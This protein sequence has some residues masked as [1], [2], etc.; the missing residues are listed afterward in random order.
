M[1][2][3]KIRIMDKTFWVLLIPAMLT[4]I[5]AVAAV[6]G[7]ALDLGDVGNRLLAVVEALFL[8]L[9]IIGIVRDPTTPG[10]DDSQRAMR[11]VEPGVLPEA[12]K[13]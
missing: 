4:L 6:F 13:E 10:V 7:F 11:Y 8:V 1:I 5:Q 12:T 3:W 2:N 9:G